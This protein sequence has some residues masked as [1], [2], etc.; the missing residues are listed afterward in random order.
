LF[1]QFFIKRKKSVNLFQAAA[2]GIIA[3]LLSIVL[4]QYKPE[5][6]MAVR[7]GA[8][9]II[10]VLLLTPVKDAIAQIGGLAA[11]AGLSG[12]YSAL[13]L[14]SLGLCIIT[15][16]SADVCRDAGEGALAGKIELAGKVTVLAMALPLIGNVAKMAA[17]LIGGAN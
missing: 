13:L 6:A 17:E 16:F 14:K 11:E 12:G 8:G 3:A 5:Y 4:K 15:Q 2:C 7:L 9:I 10:F 1:V